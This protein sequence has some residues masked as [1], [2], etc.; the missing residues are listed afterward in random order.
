MRR[1]LQLYSQKA[2]RD[3][4]ASG[5]RNG[6]ARLLRA[7]GPRQSPPPLP[8]LRVGG[9][10]DQDFL[11]REQ[12][13]LQDHH[14]EDRSSNGHAGRAALPRDVLARVRPILPGHSPR[15]PLA[16]DSNLAKA[17]SRY[18]VDAAKLAGEV[19]MEL[20]KKK[21]KGEANNPV[22]AAKPAKQK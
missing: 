2:A 9:E 15:Q 18:Q 20:S 21:A 8:R 1:R 12:R 5:P 14:P 6:R 7:A 13:G 17:A 11:G 22:K 4:I 19:R 10:K 3:A 16:K